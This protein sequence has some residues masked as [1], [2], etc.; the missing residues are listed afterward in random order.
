MR[1]SENSTPQNAPYKIIIEREFVGESDVAEVMLP[2]IV[3]DISKTAQAT[4]TF[5][6]EPISA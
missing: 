3:S 1:K 6:N 4:H 5:D 2:I